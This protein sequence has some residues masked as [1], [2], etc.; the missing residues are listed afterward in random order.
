M[1]T[2]SQMSRALRRYRLTGPSDAVPIVAALACGASADST[3]VDLVIVDRRGR[4]MALVNLVDA[5]EAQVPE[6]ASIVAQ[7]VP[8]PR[9]GLLVVSRRPEVPDDIPELELAWE[10]ACTAARRHRLVLLDWIVVAAGR[11]AFS[12]AEFTPSRPAWSM[13]LDAAGRTAGSFRR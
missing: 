2:R 6:L 12:V 8:R 1:I 11:F 4:L 5:D 7:G 10:E 13:G 9:W 3:G